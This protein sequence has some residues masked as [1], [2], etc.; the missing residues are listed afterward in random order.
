MLPRIAAGSAIVTLAYAEGTSGAYPIGRTSARSPPETVGSLT[1][2]KNYVLDGAAADL[3]YVLAD[4]AA[5]PAV[6]A[7][8]RDA[9]GLT[10]DA[11]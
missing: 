7:V 10:V 9:P 8:E 1:G 4:T 2:G 11:R 5:G 3:F 6:F